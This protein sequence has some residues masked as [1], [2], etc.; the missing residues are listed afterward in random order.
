MRSYSDYKSDSVNL[1]RRVGMLSVDAVL[2][3]LSPLEELRR[4][5]LEQRVGQ[6]ILIL[7]SPRLHLLAEL[8]K[9]PASDRP[10]DGK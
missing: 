1:I 10:P 7:D 4:H 3:V 6:N 9:L 8:V 5:L 2:L